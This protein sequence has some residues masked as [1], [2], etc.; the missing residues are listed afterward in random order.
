M[1][2]QRSYVGEQKYTKLRKTKDE[3]SVSNNDR[4]T[5]QKCLSAIDTVLIPLTRRFVDGITRQLHYPSNPILPPL[6]NNAVTLALLSGAV[7]MLQRNAG[8]QHALYTKDPL[9][10]TLIPDASI[11]ECT[12]MELLVI[13]GY[14]PPNETSGNNITHHSKHVLLQR[15]V[16]IVVNGDDDD[17]EEKD[18]ED[19][20]GCE[21]EEDEENVDTATAE[22]SK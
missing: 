4:F 19:D 9:N 5:V 13:L 22:I 6:T 18:E 16:P 1:K 10:D 7:Q 8:S 11:K 3:S 17:D 15:D 14:V 20:E 2:R 21:D 12:V